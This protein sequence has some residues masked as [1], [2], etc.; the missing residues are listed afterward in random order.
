MTRVDRDQAGSVARA[1]RFAQSAGVVPIHDGAAR[2]DHLTVLF[3][4]R[5]RQMLP[6]DQVAADGV[7]PAHMAP[8]IA[9]G[10]VLIEQVILALVEDHPVRVVHEI[11]FGRE[12]ELRPP[13]FVVKGLSERDGRQCK[14]D[15]D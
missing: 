3:G 1:G 4:Q 11:L 13:R 14:D 10:I 9:E 15:G 6:V 7:S 12:V 5:N 8:F 2:K